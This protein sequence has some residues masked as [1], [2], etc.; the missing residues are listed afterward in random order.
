MQK[1]D[2]EVGVTENA[3]LAECSDSNCT[4]ESYDGSEGVHDSNCTSESYDGSG[5]VQKVCDCEQENCACED[6]VCD[7]F[8]NEK[9][10]NAK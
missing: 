2:D 3:S 4:S 5:G 7:E 10:S 1:R 9:R 8:E 6:V